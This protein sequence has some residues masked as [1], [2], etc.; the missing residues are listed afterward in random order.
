[1]APIPEMNV[2]RLAVSMFVVPVLMALGL[3]MAVA[4]DTQP[5]PPLPADVPVSYTNL[6]LPTKD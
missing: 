4:A 2:N 5:G 1:M 6:T 3:S